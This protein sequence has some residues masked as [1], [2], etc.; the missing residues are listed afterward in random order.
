MRITILLPNCGRGGGER[1]VA[2]IGRCLVLRGHEVTVVSGGPSRRTVRAV[3]RGLFGNKP[4]VG[5]DVGC[6]TDD[7]GLRHVRLDRYRR[8][9]DEDV[10]DADWVVSTWWETAEWAVGLSASKGRKAY[11]LQQYEANF[12]AP[13][14]RVDATWRLPMKLICCSRWLADLGRTKF[15]REDMSV[16]PNGVDTQLFDAAPRGR[17][18]WPTIGFMH[19]GAFVKR[20]DLA[21]QVVDRLMVDIPQLRCVVFGGHEP[22]PGELPSGAVFVRSPPQGLLRSLYSSCDV[23]LTTSDSEGFH[24]PPHEAMACRTPVVSTRVGGPMDILRCGE[25]GFLVE[26]GD[27]EGLVACSLKVLK[28]G[29]PEWRAMSDRAYL[30][31]RAL[32]WENAAGLFEDALTLNENGKAAFIVEG[33]GHAR[34]RV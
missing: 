21:K 1:V 25:N 29:E 26:P 3:V 19:S 12:G 27:L 17:Q 6:H 15:G 8:M 23:W 9:S 31:A 28:L 18:P 20:S 4:S 22:R 30:D 11:F 34:A 32:T 16:V 5:R 33:V 14:E 2:S 13:V 7:A 24:L 10:P